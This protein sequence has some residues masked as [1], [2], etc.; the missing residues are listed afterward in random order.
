[1]VRQQSMPLAVI[2]QGKVTRVCVVCTNRV[3]D[4]GAHYLKEHRCMPA[5]KI[6]SN[7]DSHA[8][9]YQRYPVDIGGMVM[10]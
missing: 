2:R 10:V 1:M 7:F 3:Y 9:R 6:D 5:M 8:E 4:L